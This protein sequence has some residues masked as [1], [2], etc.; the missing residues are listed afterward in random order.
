[1]SMFKGRGKEGNR[2]FLAAVNEEITSDILKQ[3]FL[4]T[5]INKA[6]QTVSGQT[7]LQQGF[8]CPLQGLVVFQSLL[9]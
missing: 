8:L 9:Q 1:M 3:S 5:M 4:A 7:H 6:E 2:M